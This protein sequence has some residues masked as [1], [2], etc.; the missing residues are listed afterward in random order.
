MIF[1]KVEK[2]THTCG[3]TRKQIYGGYAYNLKIFLR[4]NTFTRQ[5]SRADQLTVDVKGSAN[6]DS[7]FPRLVMFDW[8]IENLFKQSGLWYY[9]SY[10]LLC[11]VGV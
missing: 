2:H 11:Y 10:A 4:G 7:A 8:P 5:I 9:L 3:F 6:C 1:N